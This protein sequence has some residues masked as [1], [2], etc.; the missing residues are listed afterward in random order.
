MRE[1]EFEVD[2]EVNLEYGRCRKDDCGGFS[3]DST[4]DAERHLRHGDY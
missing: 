3:Y 2:A 1:D 4:V